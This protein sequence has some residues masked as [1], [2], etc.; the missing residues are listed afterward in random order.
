[1]NAVVGARA[2][3]FQTLQASHWLQIALCSAPTTA[4]IHHLNL[5]WMDAPYQIYKVIY[6]LP[7]YDIIWLEVFGL[8]NKQITVQVMSYKKIWFCTKSM[9]ILPRVR[10]FYKA[11]EQSGKIEFKRFKGHIQ[12]NCQKNYAAIEVKVYI[13]RT[14]FRLHESKAS[15]G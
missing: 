5:C 10:W 3:C 4:F 1:M 2:Q 12:E 14:R 9:R 13:N 6:L 8:L 11:P 7:Y 15:L